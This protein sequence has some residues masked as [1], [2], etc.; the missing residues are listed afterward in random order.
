MLA[1]KLVRVARQAAFQLRSRYTAV[2]TQAK[3]SERV[4][5]SAHV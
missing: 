4:V 1:L 3:E 5:S 2:A